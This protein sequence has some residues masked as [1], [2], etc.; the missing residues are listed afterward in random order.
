[1]PL[2]DTVPLVIMQAVLLKWLNLK[3]MWDKELMY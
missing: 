2:M 1:L 3:Q